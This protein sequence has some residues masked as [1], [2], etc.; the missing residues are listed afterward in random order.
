MRILVIADD[1]SGA[2]EL[3]GIGAR[4]G[5]AARL[6][7]DAPIAVHDGLTVLDTDTRDGVRVV[8]WLMERHQR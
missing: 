3:T 7:R 5:L 2:A 8:C 6:E 4:H 1:L